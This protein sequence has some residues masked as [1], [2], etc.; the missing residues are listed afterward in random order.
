MTSNLGVHLNGN[1]SLSSA[2]SSTLQPGGDF[3][4]SECDDAK[5][6]RY[7]M[8]EVL[9]DLHIKL[10]EKIVTLEEA[11][12]TKNKS[13]FIPHT[14][15]N[16]W[17]TNKNLNTEL[18]KEYGLN[19]IKKLSRKKFFWT[20]ANGGK[21]VSLSD[22]RII[23]EKEATITSI[24]ANLR[25]PIQVV[26]L[27][28]E[29]MEEL[30]KIVESRNPPG[31]P[32]IPINGKLVCEELQRMRSFRSRN[33]I[34]DSNSHDSLFKLLTFILQDETSF[35]HLTKLP[36]I[37]LSDGSVGE[38]GGEQVYYIGE[39]KYIDLFPS[40]GPSKFISVG[41]FNVEHKELLEIFCSEKF[42]EITNI[43]KFDASAVL[44]LL[45]DELP[46]VSKLP[47]SPNGTSVPNSSWLDEIWS[48]L[49]KELESIDFDELSRFPLLPLT[50]SS[51]MLVQ[52]DM[53][54]PVLYIP[55]NVEYPLFEV[56]KKLKLSI[57]NM[58]IPENAHEDLKN[59]V[60]QLTAFSI[61]N[62]L[63]RAL[64]DNIDDTEQLLEDDDLYM[65]SMTQF[66][67]E[68]DLLP[69]DYEEFRK[70][71]NYYFETLIGK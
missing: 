30:R 19:V 44:A 4:E 1:F 18:F 65:E 54:N 8:L 36:L 27:N 45:E 2:R 21:F 34:I 31:F 61:L 5:W 59:C 37:P 39:Q 55:G 32:Y 35:K 68:N 41:L 49:N 28:E 50:H 16:F 12:Y 40:A 33:N 17:P 15:G 47:W 10:L 3:L 58:K 56:L 13:N 22:A 62:S 52:P 46:N 70:F 53:R 20:E 11:R 63:E 69:S 57:T 43:K 9:P 42:S 48:I 29:K 66:F 71:I 24:L 23:D 51:H 7:I 67:E 25:I 6:N 60:A 14:T 64:L 38:F 26:K